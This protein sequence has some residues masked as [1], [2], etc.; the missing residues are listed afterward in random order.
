MRERRLPPCVLALLVEVSTLDLGGGG[1]GGGGHV[2]T[3]QRRMQ[4]P[5][6]T[7][8]SSSAPLGSARR[9]L[10]PRRL[11]RHQPQ[12][13]LSSPELSHP[14]NCPSSGGASPIRLGTY[15]LRLLLIRTRQWPPAPPLR[16][17]RAPDRRRVISASRA[18]EHQA[19]RP[20]AARAAGEEKNKKVTG[21][22]TRK[23]RDPASPPNHAGSRAPAA[24]FRRIGRVSRTRSTSRS[25]ARNQVRAQ[26]QQ[27]RTPPP[28]VS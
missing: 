16:A 9:L 5:V 13:S 14:S 11:R 25:P 17:A 22:R 27:P 3:G 23:H 15:L 4:Q 28:R 6:E 18:D 7:A 10:L 20:L 8:V 24:R 1:G 2:P 21:S 26:A 12:R 19:A